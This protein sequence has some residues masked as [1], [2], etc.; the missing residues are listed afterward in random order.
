MQEILNTFGRRGVWISPYI[1]YC[2]SREPVMVANKELAEFEFRELQPSDSEAIAVMEGYG[3]TEPTISERFA[4]GE[5]AF[6]AFIRGQLVAIIWASLKF[7]QGLGN[8]PA[9]RDLESDEAYM[10]GAYTLREY[11]G[12][13]IMTA[14]RVPFRRRLAEIGRHKCYSVNMLFNRS[15][16]RL[17]VKIG[18][19]ELELRLSVILFD[20]IRKD[21]LLRN[22][23]R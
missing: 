8:M 13:G 21:V 16:R 5:V 1:V 17:K 11:R 7:F 3:V 12:G 6:G 22:L 2:E 15:A 4:E 9:V 10:H 18:A 23:S 14:L 20:R 19:Q